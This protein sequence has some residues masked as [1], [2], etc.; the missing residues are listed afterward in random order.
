MNLNS[1]VSLESIYKFNT[2]DPFWGASPLS[3]EESEYANEI[4][5]VLNGPGAYPILDNEAW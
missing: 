4:S 5:N 2:D 3:Y 1:P